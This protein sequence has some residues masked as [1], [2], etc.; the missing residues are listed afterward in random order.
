MLQKYLDK[1]YRYT[2]CIIK[3]NRIYFSTKNKSCTLLFKLIKL[4]SLR[5]ITDFETKLSFIWS[6][7]T[8]RRETNN[9]MFLFLNKLSRIRKL[10]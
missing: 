10:V 3:S 2:N 8:L 5:D 6:L 9:E 4:N 1:L 7:K